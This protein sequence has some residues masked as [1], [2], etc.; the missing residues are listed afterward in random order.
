[1]MHTLIDEMIAQWKM[2]DLSTKLNTMWCVCNAGSC[3]PVRRQQYPADSPPALRVL[4][5]WQGDAMGQ[6]H[7]YTVEVASLLEKAYRCGV[8][9]VDLSQHSHSLPYVVHLASMTQVCGD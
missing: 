1:M 5:Q 8:A 7:L 9:V 4:W 3:R 2:N 6:W